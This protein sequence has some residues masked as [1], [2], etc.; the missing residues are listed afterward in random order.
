MF[1]G[2]ETFGTPFVAVLHP[3]EG[4]GPSFSYRQLRC[5]VRNPTPSSSLKSMSLKYVSLTPP[6]VAVL[7][8]P[9]SY[10]Q[11]RCAVRLIPTLGALPPP[12]RARPGCVSPSLCLSLSV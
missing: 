10:R 5:A 6:F 8:G 12:R 11:L 9:F 7:H 2:L 3:Q 1:G 4:E